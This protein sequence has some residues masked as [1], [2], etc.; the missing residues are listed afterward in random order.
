M[1]LPLVCV[2]GW[3]LLELHRHIMVL[4][5]ENRAYKSKVYLQEEEMR[6]MR[7]TE[8]ARQVPEV[9]KEDAPLHHRPV[10]VEYRARLRSRQR[11][12]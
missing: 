12:V 7:E 6:K 1:L 4:T 2:Q 9:D 5:E 11:S 8:R 10:A 3:L